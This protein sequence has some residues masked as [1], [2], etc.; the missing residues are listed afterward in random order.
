MEALL[1]LFEARFAQ[2]PCTPQ[3]GLGGRALYS[4]GIRGGSDLN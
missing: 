3:E 2:Q 4:A 1:A